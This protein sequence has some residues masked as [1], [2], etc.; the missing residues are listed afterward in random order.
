MGNR[1]FIEV[2]YN[3][4]LYAGF[5][6][7]KNANTIQAEV[8][9]ALFTFYRMPIPL[10]GSSR[11]DAGVH[12]RQNYFHLDTDQPL[13]EKEIYHLNAILPADIV[14]KSIQLVKADAHCRF[15]AL[16]R[17]YVYSVY[18]SKDPFLAES[19]YHFPYPVSQALLS[20]AAA[21]VLEATQFQNFSKKNT[22]V[23]TYECKIL[24]SH[25]VFEQDKMSYHIIANRF[26]RGMVKALTGTMLRVGRGQLSVELFEALLAGQPGK[27]VDFSVPSH[28]LC[29]MEVKF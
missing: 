17:Y 13:L 24:Q 28:G 20:E 3:G 26:L 10:T 16:S 15:D 8:E 6:K 14:I 21:K 19:A 9:K 11:T 7:Q 4:K 27:G 2:A 18:Q 22:Q 23:F 12:A 25:W 1:Y 5:Q 29:L